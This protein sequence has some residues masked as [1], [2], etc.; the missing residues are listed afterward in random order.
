MNK[1]IGILVIFVGAFAFSGGCGDKFLC[2]DPPEG[3]YVSSVTCAGDV[4]VEC[5]MKPCPSGGGGGG[6]G[7]DDDCNGDPSGWI[8]GC[9]LFA[10]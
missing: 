4:V 6:G 10:M 2:C 8:F 3:Y 5:T 9:D 7:D 1:A